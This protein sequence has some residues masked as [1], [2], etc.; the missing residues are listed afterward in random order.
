[1]QSKIPVQNKN[2]IEYAF[3]SDEDFEELSKY[4]WH[5]QMEG[6][7]ACYS[8]PENYTLMHRFVKGYLE[9]QKIGD[10]N[11][12]DHIDGNKL[13]NRR[14][15]L[16]IVTQK[17]NSQNRSKRK[18]VTSQY[19]GVYKLKN[20]FVSN[21]SVNDVT[22][23]L[24]VYENEIDAA[25]AHDRF[26]LDQTNLDELVYKFNFP[27][28][29]ETTMLRPVFIK[30][31]KRTS[32]FLG[33]HKMGN[34][35]V[36]CIIKNGVKVLNFRSVNEHDCVLA[37]DKAVVENGLNMPLNF[38]FMYPNY[39]P[40][41]PV[42]THILF[43][44]GSIIIVKPSNSEICVTVIDSE[45][46]DNIKNYSLFLT[47]KGYIEILI[48]SKQIRLHRYLMNVTEASVYVD[49]IDGDKLNNKLE[50]LRL[51]DAQRNAE[52]KRKQSG[53]TSKYLG[54]STS[55][56]KSKRFLKFVAQVGKLNFSKG[57]NVEEHAA[58]K[59][60]LVIMKH[61]PGSHYNFNFIWSEQEIQKWEE[62]LK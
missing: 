42:K 28:D 57:Y 44:I 40:V 50:N 21:I 55:K 8:L 26:L 31:E 3:C 9:K 45:Q 1:M 2:T 19:F 18:D 43:A 56:S 25:R 46:Y 54:V 11:V 32:K 24:G 37:Y 35:F 62:I 14:H 6:Y 58:R 16:R 33:V 29:K 38:A 48:G 23:Y 15:M 20:K 59:R 13:D 27:N 5:K 60:D 61:L 36:A 49:H 17:Q 30:K 52:N 51:S 10:G 4:R 47:K 22:Y 12:V 39:V 53:K 7:A 34:K 41:V